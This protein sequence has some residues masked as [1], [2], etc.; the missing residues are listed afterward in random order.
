[1][2]RL[3]PYQRRMSE[4]DKNPYKK[5]SKIFIGDLGTYIEDTGSGT[6]DIVSP[7]SLISVDGDGN[8]NISGSTAVTISGKNLDFSELP[9]RYIR[10]QGISWTWI[11]SNT[12][13]VGALPIRIKGHK[14][15]IP[16]INLE[17]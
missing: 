3:T 6:Y 5:A 9:D 7:K 2:S 1:M 8:V 17:P 13:V 12:E 4:K 16:F 10:P 15:Y 14:V 11:A